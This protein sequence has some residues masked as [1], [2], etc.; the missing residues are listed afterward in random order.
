MD[1]RGRGSLS[2]PLQPRKGGAWKYFQVPL[3]TVKPKLCQSFAGTGSSCLRQVELAV[4]K[5]PGVPG[6]QKADRAGKVRER[7]VNQSQPAI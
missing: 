3:G 1:G 6:R 5:V 4:S 2:R 7:S